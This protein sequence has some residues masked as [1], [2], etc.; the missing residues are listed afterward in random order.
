MATEFRKATPMDVE[1][2]WMVLDGARRHMIEIGRHQWTQQYPSRD[3]VVKD[4]DGGH[5]YLLLEDKE[6]VAYAAVAVNGEPEYEHMH[7]KWISEQDYIMMHR[8]A[9]SM[10]HRGKGLARRYFDEVEHLAQV[11]DIHSIKVDTN[12]DNVEM[13]AL[14]PRLGYEYCGEVEYGIKGKRLAFEKLI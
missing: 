14:L 5:A 6:V 4:I 1:K 8:L 11:I 3:N 2:A 12:Y 10:A 7:G 13:L 9:V